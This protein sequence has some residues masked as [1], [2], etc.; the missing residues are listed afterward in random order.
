MDWSKAKTIL[1]VAFLIT[2]ILLGVVLFLSGRQVETATKEGFIEDVTKLLN[3]KNI[4]IDTE[5]SREIPSLNTLIVEY[6]ILDLYEINKN[7]FNGEG[8]IESTDQGSKGIIYNN[9]YVLIENRKKLTYENNNEEEKYTNLNE[10]QAKTI[11]L[12]FLQDKNYDTSDMLLYYAKEQDNSYR[13]EFSKIYNSRYVER[14]NTIVEV[15]KR[16]VKKLERIWLRALDEGETPIYISTA[17]KAILSLLSM[18]EVYGKTIKDISL[19]YYFDPIEQDYLKEYK[20]P[21][22]GK[23]NPAWRVLFD[24]GYKVIIDNY[25]R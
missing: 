1:I 14:A 13:L 3:N 12:E 11:A 18:E 7:Y 21:K 16:G 8:K 23:A 10:E 2:N 22:K 6:E 4:L 15:D 9:E 25:N 19:C 17:P 5:I 24:D 20:N